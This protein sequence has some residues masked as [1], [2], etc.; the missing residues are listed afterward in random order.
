[1]IEIR[2]TTIDLP[3]GSPATV[4]TAGIDIQDDR[5]EVACS[6]VEITEEMVEAGAWVIDDWREIDDTRALA[7][8]VYNAMAPAPEG[9]ARSDF[10]LRKEIVALLD[11]EF[12]DSYPLSGRVFKEKAEAVADAILMIVQK[13][14]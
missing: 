2:R 5:F 8:R 14:S 9:A 1:M 7:V 4:L 10:A 6:P 12:S 11:F 13:Q 3:D